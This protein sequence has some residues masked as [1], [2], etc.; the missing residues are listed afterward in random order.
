[1]SDFEEFE[2]YEPRVEHSPA[3]YGNELGVEVDK[4]CQVV[5]GHVIT[6]VADSIDHSNH[7]LKTFEGIE[8]CLSNYQK[9]F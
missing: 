7:E 5:K 9:A 4:L 8:T 3:D 2:A 1:M 6:S